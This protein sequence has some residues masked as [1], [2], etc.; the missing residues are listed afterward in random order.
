MRF[1]PFPQADFEQAEKYLAAYTADPRNAP[2]EVLAVEV[3]VQCSLPPHPYD[4][5]GKPV[6]LSGTLDQIR[7]GPSVWDYKTGEYQ[8]PEMLS[9][10]LPQLAGYA[11]AGAS[12]YPGLSAGGIIRGR[13][14]HRRRIKGQAP[15][16]PA[17]APPGI[18]FEAGMN[19]ETCEVILAY[20]RFVVAG[21]RRGEVLLGPG[22]YCVR[23]CPFGGVGSCEP[24][25][26]GLSLKVV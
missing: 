1:G 6:Y 11:L 7:K 8:G 4:P 21:I 14:Y 2:E 5:T 20:V 23:Q 26:R 24:L 17:D 3:K 16:D 13:G 10:F 18:F 25:A 15:I 12:I 22:D 9:H 19:Q